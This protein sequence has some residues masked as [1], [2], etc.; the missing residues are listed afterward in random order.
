HEAAHKPAQP[1]SRSEIGSGEKAK[2]EAETE[3]DE[4]G[5]ERDIDRLQH[6]I[7]IFRYVE[8]IGHI[9]SSIRIVELQAAIVIGRREIEKGPPHFPAVSRHELADEIEEIGKPIEKLAGIR[10][11]CEPKRTAQGREHQEKAANR[12]EAASR[13][14]R[15]PMLFDRMSRGQGYWGAI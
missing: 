8:A 3:T 15:L 6:V 1:P 14:E 2:D 12:V 7:E 13:C 4:R 5:N 9:D 10:F 11:I